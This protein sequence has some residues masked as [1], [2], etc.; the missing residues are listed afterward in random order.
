MTPGFTPHYHPTT[1]GVYAASAPTPGAG[2]Y[3]DTR[4]PGAVF[5]MAGDPRTPGG[6]PE[7]GRA[8]V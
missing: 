8:H 4:T 2:M 6:F 5:G 1:P 7:I 3:D